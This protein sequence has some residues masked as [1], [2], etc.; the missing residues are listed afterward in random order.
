MPQSKSDSVDK[1]FWKNPIRCPAA[2]LHLYFL[3]L[4]IPLVIFLSVWTPPFL[5]P[6]EPGHFARAYQIA[7][8]KILGS[9]GGYI[10]EGI[11]R[12]WNYI[13]EGH[14]PPQVHY[15]PE[16]RAGAEEIPW[17]GNR[18]FYEFPN[19]AQYSPT[20]YLPQALGIMLGKSVGAGVARTLILARLFNGMMAILVCTFALFWCRAGKVFMFS[21]LLLPMTLCLFASASQDASLIAFTSLAFSLISRQLTEGSALSRGKIIVLLVLFLVISLGRPP[22]AALTLVL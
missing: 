15:S 12:L 20:G 17:T 6:D 14:F 7:G 10:D 1:G 19:I 3:F 22:Y 11:L 5:S 8:G 21:V 16:Y 18:V 13:S 2:S 9:D 4:S